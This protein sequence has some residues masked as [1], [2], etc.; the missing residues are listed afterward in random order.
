MDANLAGKT[1]LVT[2]ATGGIGKEIARGLVE[3]GAHVIV[4]G[5]TPERATATAAEISPDRVTPLAVDVADQGSVRSFAAAVR[6]D[7]PALDILVNNA[8][9]WFT[10]RQTSPDGIEL[11]LATNVIGPHLLTELLLDTLRAAPSAR[12]VNIVSSIQGSYDVTDLA[13]TRRPFDGYKAY[14]QSKRALSMLTWGLAA[15]LAGTS[16]TA[17]AAAPG[18]VKTGFNRHTHGMR[19]TMI[20]ISAKL[21]AVSPAKGA[22]T[23]IWVASASELDGVTGKYF[24]ARKEKNVEPVPP[25]AIAALEDEC[26][27]LETV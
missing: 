13:F 21:F 5:R 18:F 11:T 17:N 19:A 9:A 22:D 2:G 10:D 25:E 20:N 14:G 16:V 26:R 8:G 4:G 24:E 6:S 23:P 7:F 15:R 12:V 1:A 27:R 3:R